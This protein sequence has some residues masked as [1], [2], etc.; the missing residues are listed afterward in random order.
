MNS[1]VF[2]IRLDHHDAITETQSLSFLLA[3]YWLAV[4]T[5]VA[6]AC[7]KSSRRGKELKLQILFGSKFQFRLERCV[8]TTPFDV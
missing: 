8:I 2:F 4:V 7:T 3:F 1:F 6:E 5:C